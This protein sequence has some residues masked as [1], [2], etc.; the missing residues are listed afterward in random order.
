LA[1]RD[2]RYDKLEHLVDQYDKKMADQE[3]LSQINKELQETVNEINLRHGATGIIR[4]Q[5]SSYLFK[6]VIE[7]VVPSHVRYLIYS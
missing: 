7:K 1:G 5:T 6:K 4:R 2:V 3:D